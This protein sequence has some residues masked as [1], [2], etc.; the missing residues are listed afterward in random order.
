M[1]RIRLLAPLLL[2]LAGCGSSAQSPPQALSAASRSLVHLPQDQAGHPQSANEWWYVVGH[3]R[4]GGRL[5][6]Y[7]MTIFRFSHIHPPGSG[8]G[9]P[10][11]TLYRTD[12]AIT[13][14]AG[15]TFH[16]KISYYFPQS[17]RISSTSLSARVG[18]ARLSGESPRD[19]RLSFSMPRSSATLRLSSLRSEMDVGGRGYLRFSNGFTYYYSLTDVATT[20]KLTVAGKTYA[21]IGTSWLDHQWGNWT[22]TG[23][24]GWTWMA[25]QLDN[26][27]QLSVFD[28]RSPSGT[29]HAASILLPGGRLLTLHSVSFKPLGHWTSPHTHATYPSGFV[30][31]IPGVKARLRVLPTLKDQEL[32]I[33]SQPQ[34]SYWEGSSTV[35]GTWQGHPVTGLAYTE[36]TGYAK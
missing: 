1:S 33:A 34:G 5:F 8:S 14:E 18:T 30:L 35:R 27:T 3:L 36:L 28:I 16:Q 12:L 17:A 11:V 15:S 10:A 26:H 21:V 25:L 23:V 7:E 29:T 19:M 32:W 13:D 9:S 2:V 24:K 6:G 31:T 22:W 20:G 4:S